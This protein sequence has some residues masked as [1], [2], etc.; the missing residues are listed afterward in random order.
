MLR[1]L[2][3]CGGEIRCWKLEDYTLTQD[4]Y[5]ISDSSEDPEASANISFELLK[6]LTT[7]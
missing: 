6:F 5:I 2:V 1:S 3:L 7:V 4:D